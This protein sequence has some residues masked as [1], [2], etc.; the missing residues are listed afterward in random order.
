MNLFETS[1]Y[2]ERRQK[3]KHELKTGK[4]LFLGNSEA[5][6]NYTDNHF[7]FRQDSSFLY[8]FGLNKPD[9]AAII[10]V[11]NDQEI[12]FG[13]TASLDDIIWTGASP[14]L[15]DLASKVGIN[16]VLEYEKLKNNLG[17][18]IHYLPQYRADNKIKLSEYLGQKLNEKGSEKFVKAVVKCRSIKGTEEVLAM[19]DAVNISGKMHLAAY[20]AI[21]EGRKEYE[22]AAILHATALENH[23]DLSYPIICSQNGQYL[24][25]HDHS[26]TL[27]NGR[28]LLVDSGAENRQ[29]YA[30]DITRTWPVAKQFTSQQKE[31]Y[32]IVLNMEES[33]IAALKAGVQYKDMHLL[34]NTILIDSFKSLGILKGV[35]ELMLNEGVAGLFMPHGLGHMIGMDV[36]DMEDLGENFVGY[37]EGQTRSTQLGLKSLRLA[38]TL[39]AG[40]ALTVEPGIYFI[41]ALLSSYKANGAFKDFVDY[42]KL[43]AYEGFGGIRIEDNVLITED[44]HTLLGEP[45]LKNLI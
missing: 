7:R 3:L 1:V 20:H 23:A 19:H 11:D 37:K 36:H 35:T 32:D 21:A 13:N 2:V 43:D 16:T 12:I 6:M 45:I 14:A 30:G 25:N 27:Q 29:I 10:D 38:R 33:V 15:S 34:A 24:H 41:P 17:A 18:D 4:Y 28:L 39:E 31:I 22:I 44:G 40:M 8:F 26:A 5:P 42:S 9:L